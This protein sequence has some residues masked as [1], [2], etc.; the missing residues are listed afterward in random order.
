MNLGWLGWVITSPQFHRVH[1]SAA[2]EHLDKNFGGHF[3]VFDHLFRTAGRSTDVYPETGIADSQ[4]PNE[5]NL[6]WSGLPGNWLRQTIYPFVQLFEEQH[7]LQRGRVFI[8]NVRSRRR[9]R[10]SGF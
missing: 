8:E 7:V 6:K 4:F 10:A 2:P 5:D 3:S 9:R 1:H